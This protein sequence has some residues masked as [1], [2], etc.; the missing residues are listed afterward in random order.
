[1]AFSF[2]IKNINKVT[3]DLFYQLINQVANELYTRMEKIAPEAKFEKH[4]M[5][6]IYDEKTQ[7][8]TLDNN[9]ISS[10]LLSKIANS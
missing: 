4:K 8:L 10:E 7:Q 1:M 6:F 5:V 9:S 2:K 3:D